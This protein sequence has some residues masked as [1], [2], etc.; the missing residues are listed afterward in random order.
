MAKTE[1]VEIHKAV[2]LA[3][4]V[5][6]SRTDWLSLSSA[7]IEFD[8]NLRI[9]DWSEGATDILRFDAN[10]VIGEGLEILF[11]QQE[12]EHIRA[13]WNELLKSGKSVS[14]C[15][16]CV[17]KFGSFVLREGFL[18]VQEDTRH[19]A[20]VLTICGPDSPSLWV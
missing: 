17:D 14:F 2:Q 7:T 5:P 9:R 1:H 19:T 16:A 20:C 13:K 15:C 11:M 18:S 12:L 3:K 4:S 6:N 10:E 8:Q